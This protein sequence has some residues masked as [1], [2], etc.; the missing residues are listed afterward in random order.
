MEVQASVSESFVPLEDV[1]LQLVEELYPLKS[2]PHIRFKV[3]FVIS[4][5]QRKCSEILN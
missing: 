5:Q 2:K 1:R 3:H 4:H